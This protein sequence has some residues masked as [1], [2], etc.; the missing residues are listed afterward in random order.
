MCQSEQTGTLMSNRRARV[1]M[2]LPI[3]LAL[4]FALAAVLLWIDALF[5]GGAMMG[6]M[7][8][9]AAALMGSPNGWMLVVTL[10][11][12]VLAVFGTLLGQR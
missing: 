4:L 3:I 9:G 5:W 2:N 11:V 7:M 8:H 12:V 6:G 10:V 1:L